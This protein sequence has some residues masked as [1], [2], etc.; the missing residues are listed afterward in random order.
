MAERLY[1]KPLKV[2]DTSDR[3]WR[4][5]Y[6]LFYDG[7]SGKWTGYYPTRALAKFAAFWNV[8]VGSWGGSAVLTDQQIIYVDMP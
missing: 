4:V 3:R 7:G 2:K 5:D 8:R 1:P 6:D